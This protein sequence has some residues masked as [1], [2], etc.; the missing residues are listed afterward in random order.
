M[1]LIFIQ[2]YTN[3]PGA[4]AGG[5]DPYFSNV[6]LLMHMDGTVGGTTFLDVK[7][8]TATASNV[9]IQ[10]SGAKFGQA[11]QFAGTSTSL[12]S[13]PDS[14]D[15]AFGGG[16]L[17][18]EYWINMASIPD[19]AVCPIGK[20]PTSWLVYMNPAGL[21]FFIN[22]GTIAVSSNGPTWNMGEWYHI[23]VTRQSSTWNIWVNGVS[24]AANS[25]ASAITTGTEPLA[26]GI[27]NANAR[28][29]LNGKLDDVRITKGVARYTETFVP[30][31][32]PF[33]D[34]DLTYDPYFSDVKFLTHA[35]GTAGATS[36]TEQLS[37]NVKFFGNSTLSST[38]KFGTTAVSI[39]DTT[40]G[41]AVTPASGV[42]YEIGAN[43]F[44]LEAW[45]YRTQATFGS[46]AGTYRWFF[47]YHGGYSMMLDQNG[48]IIF[49][50][51]ST[52]VVQSPNGVV[53]MNQWFHIATTRVGST[54]RFFVN[55]ALVHTATDATQFV[56]V[57]SGS[58]SDATGHDNAP[59]MK[60]GYRP[61]DGSRVQQFIGY[62]DEVR[63]TVGRARYTAAFAA[64]TAPFFDVGPG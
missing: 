62:I 48:A 13:I 41:V 44:T 38:A 10:S 49:Y 40:A 42:S 34:T 55:G 28:N 58:S 17:T 60:I 7:G 18:I 5:A 37:G 63:L 47:G 19:I 54:W 31:T 1:P 12:M 46:I 59:D 56:A 35:D 26:L 6:S 22:G 57:D 20:W 25:N 23:A 29:F 2:P 39:P 8:H 61:S 53:P 33:P 11:A 21:Y 32:A 14:A 64:P 36:T 50:I 15:F 43:D 30:P 52:V 9:T 24:V 3:S 27:N 4:G 16:D 51:S 45:A